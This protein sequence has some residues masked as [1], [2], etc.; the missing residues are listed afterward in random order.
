[1]GSTVEIYQGVSH[2]ASVDTEFSNVED[3]LEMAFRKTLGILGPWENAIDSKI[4][5]YS[6]D[7]RSSYIGD[8]FE[9]D[10]TKYKLTGSGF[11]QILTISQRFKLRE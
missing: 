8:I 4:M 3:A 10:G 7:I 9:V 1:M 6:P 2:V 5:L 11:K